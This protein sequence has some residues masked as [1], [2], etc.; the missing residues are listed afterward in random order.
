MYRGA[1]EGSPVFLLNKMID[2]KNER[3]SA[4]EAGNCDS[5][6]YVSGREAL[7]TGNRTDLNYAVSNEYVSTV[8]D[9]PDETGAPKAQESVT[10]AEFLLDGERLVP[11]GDLVRVIDNGHGLAWGTDAYLL[12]AFVRR[13]R[14]ACELGSGCGVISFLV[15]THNKCDTLVSIELNP[16]AADRTRRGAGVNGL[17]GRVSVIERDIRTVK[18]TDEDIGRRFDCVIS[19]PPYI[20]HEGLKNCDKTADDARHENNGG[21]E[22]FCAAAARLLN[23]RGSFYVVFRPER[24]TDLFCALRK[25][26]LEPKRAVLVYPDAGSKPSLFLCEAVLGAAPGLDFCPPLLFYKNKTAPREMTERMAE[27]YRDCRF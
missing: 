13:H 18:Y 3:F 6:E 1:P 22:D 15:A 8:G 4:S 27:I 17:D 7:S 21:I 23:H 24:M 20:A 25:N 26:R 9:A 12:S 11:V 5:P 19:N 16:D 10:S 14:R 2:D